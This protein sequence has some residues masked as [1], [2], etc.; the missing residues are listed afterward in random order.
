MIWRPQSTGNSQLDEIL[1]QMNKDIQD[2][3]V[4]A[5]TTS[6]SGGSSSS[7]VAGVTTQATG[8][9]SLTL[10][11]PTNIANGITVPTTGKYF[12]MLNVQTASAATATLNCFLKQ[13]SVQIGNTF[14]IALA[15]NNQSIVNFYLITA[16]AGDVLQLVVTPS[17]TAA[18]FFTIQTALLRQI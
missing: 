9:L 13:N 3:Q 7:V 2:L 15:N 12:F 17:V 11:V 5:K 18:Y 1:R 4:K 10:N 14:T 8:S 16:A 6:T